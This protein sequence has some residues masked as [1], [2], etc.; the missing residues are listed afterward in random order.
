MPPVVAYLGASSPVVIIVGAAITSVIILPPPFITSVT[1]PPAP[2]YSTAPVIIVGAPTASL[3]IPDAPTYST[4][5][6]YCVIGD[7][8][9]VVMIG[10]CL[11][12]TVGCTTTFS[13]TATT[14]ASKRSRPRVTGC[15]P[16]TTISLVTLCWNARCVWTRRCCDT[17]A[18]CFKSST[19]CTSGTSTAVS[20]MRLQGTFTTR[21]VTSVVTFGIPLCTICTCSLG[22][23]LTTSAICVCGT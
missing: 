7:A 20:Q 19:V 6:P 22:T 16:V 12:T 2:T 9:V 11:S 21:S 23:C 18:V 13:F 10:D 5:A 14:G 15:C 1:I 3:N 4:P 17:A 8:K